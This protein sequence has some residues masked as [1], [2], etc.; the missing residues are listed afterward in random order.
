MHRLIVGH[1]HAFDIAQQLLGEARYKDHFI[2]CSICEWNGYVFL[3]GTTILPEGKVN[4][5]IK[6]TDEVPTTLW[7][8]LKPFICPYK[9]M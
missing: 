4:T 5:F 8:D 7:F 1:W 3:D 2:D 9:P 6:E